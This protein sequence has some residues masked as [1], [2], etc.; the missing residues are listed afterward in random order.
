MNFDS[1]ISGMIYCAP[2]EVE[3]RVES[4]ELGWS[5]MGLKW[6]TS[7]MYLKGLFKKDQNSIIILL[8]LPV[9]SLHVKII[10]IMSDLVTKSKFAGSHVMVVRCGEIQYKICKW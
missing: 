9:N 10:F 7:K 1:I 5:K 8:I 6:N 3:G 4:W 2:N